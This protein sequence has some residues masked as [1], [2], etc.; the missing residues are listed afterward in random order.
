MEPLHGA[1]WPAIPDGVTELPL[2]FLTGVFFAMDGTFSRKDYTGIVKLT[3]PK[4]I[5]N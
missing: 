4:S 3:D 2:R 1:A 5:C